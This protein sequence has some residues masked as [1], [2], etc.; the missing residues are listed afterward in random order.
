MMF[1][2]SEFPKALDEAVFATWLEDGRVS[3][4]S[5]Q[6]LLIVWDALEQEYQPVY[7]AERD[8][9]QKYEPYQQATG[10]E[11]LIAAYDLY[12]ESRVA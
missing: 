12:S 2:G 8:H 6:Y 5:H 7:V 3:L 4:L 1:D 11:S 9:I 10:R